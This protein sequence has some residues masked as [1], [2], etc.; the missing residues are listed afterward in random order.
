MYHYNLFPSSK[1]TYS[2][3]LNDTGRFWQLTDNAS[4]VIAESCSWR[5]LKR[6]AEYKH[7]KV[8]FY[9]DG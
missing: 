2:I 5:E 3:H 9:K 1:H 4:G 7:L 8:T 6:W